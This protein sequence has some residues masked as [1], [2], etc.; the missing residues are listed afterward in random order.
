MEENQNPWQQMEQPEDPV[1]VPRYWLRREANVQGGALLIYQVILNVC[2]MIVVFAVSFTGA[3]QDALLGKQSDFEAMMNK[4]VAASG[5]GY[6]VAIVIGLGILLLWRKPR[7]LGYIFRRKQKRMTFGTFFALLALVMAPQVPAQLCNLG[8]VWLLEAMG[9]DPAVLDQLA[10]VDTGSLSMFLYV[11][12]L[13]PISE[14]LIFRGWVLRAL[15]P[16]GKRFSIVASALLFGLFHGNLL[17]APYAFLVGLVMGYVA[18]EVKTVF[19]T[20]N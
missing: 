4:A 16:Y 13:A 11:G 6:L 3:L 7:F 19:A 1:A 20:V 8:L 15:R 10:N 5:W 14:E 9:F 2:V 17:Q 18:M 12:I